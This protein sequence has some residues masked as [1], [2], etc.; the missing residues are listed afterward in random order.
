MISTKL[1]SAKSLERIILFAGKK[2]RKHLVFDLLTCYLFIFLFFSIFKS[3][4]ATEKKPVC[5]EKNP[6]PSETIN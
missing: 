5:S 6:M 1:A 3:C 2:A 4:T